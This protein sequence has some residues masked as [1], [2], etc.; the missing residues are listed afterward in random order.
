MG[1]KFAVSMNGATHFQKP[2]NRNPQT[3]S[4][5]ICTGF[6]AAL[7]GSVLITLFASSALANQLTLT[8]NDNSDNED[9]FKVERSLDGASFDTIGSAAANV[10]TYLDTTIE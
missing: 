8:W 9:G 7:M 1:A 3:I 10:S 6:W 5:S 4:R 2:S